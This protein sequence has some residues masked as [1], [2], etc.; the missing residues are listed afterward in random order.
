M[1]DKSANL[2]LSLT[3]RFSRPARSAA[4][5]LDRVGAAVRR[6]NR[7]TAAAGVGMGRMGGAMVA[8]GSAAAGLL[9]PVAGAKGMRQTIVA[10]ADFQTALTN[11][12]KKA[13]TTAEQTARIGE[14]IKSLATSGDLAVPIEE[15]AAAYERGAASG[16]P[17]DELRQFALLSAKAAD[18][19]EMSASDV[20]NAAAGFGTVMK[21]PMKDMARYFDLINGLADTGIANEA[22]L[23]NFLD[24]AG[25]SLKLFGLSAEQA[26][27]YGATLANIKMPPDVAA[28]A[29]S[30]LTG[31]LLS[32]GSETA[33]I[34]LRNIVGDIDDF[35]K[36]LK[37]DANKGLLVFLDRLAKLD[38]FR[39]TELL[40]GFVGAGFDDEILRLAAAT[41]EARKNLDYAAGTAWFGSLDAAYKLKLR[42]FWSQWQLLKNE[43]ERAA[44]D[45][46]TAGMPTLI[47]GL[48]NVRSLVR[49]IGEGFDQM[50]VDI[51]WEGVDRASTAVGE[52]K[53]ALSEALGID[54]SNSEIMRFFKD[55]ATIVNDIS[56]GIVFIKNQIGIIKETPMGQVMFGD[57]KAR[58][59]GAQRMGTTIDPKT[60]RLAPAPAKP[61]G[62]IPGLTEYLSERSGVG[63][64]G[65]SQAARDRTGRVPLSPDEQIAARS[66]DAPAASPDMRSAIDAYAARQAALPRNLGTSTGVM[67]TPT[68]RPQIAEPVRQEAAAAVSAAEQAAAAILSALSLTVAP[69]VDPG[70]IR[71]ALGEANALA[72]ALDSLPGKAR[73]AAQAIQDASVGG[74]NFSMQYREELHGLHADISRAG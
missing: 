29:L 52:F 44:I 28:N 69:I 2:I 58:Q 62:L 25:A 20:G 6:N 1:A 48:E 63:T 15:I 67:A 18:A 68:P 43:V 30:T 59:E 37:K 74:R 17:L 39:A 11:I 26:A 9:A 46:G 32:P 35:Q 51:D 54:G 16:I 23:I 47:R 61:G 60:G 21:I 57:E 8:A 7:L 33:Q 50:V 22:D 73:A 70:S 42:D 38:K 71:A 4:N 31:K 10:A 65:G 14:E 24:R 66:G 12:Q 40:G 41:D 56:E 3:D 55:V 5:E 34:A 36:I 53:T 64:L 19:F 27:A 49:S 45:F 72:R 13:G